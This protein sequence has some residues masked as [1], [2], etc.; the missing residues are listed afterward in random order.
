[1]IRLG[2]SLFLMLTVTKAPYRQATIKIK[3]HRLRVE[4]A[5]TETQRQRGMMYRRELPADHG[6]LFVFPRDDRLVFWM[7]N[8]VIPLSIAFIDKSG[9]IRRILR[10]KPLDI[11][12][13][14]A[15]GV[16]VRYALEVNRGW[17]ARHGIKTGDTV[18]LPDTVPQGQ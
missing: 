4:L 17:F 18:S 8:T 3:G 11:S 13:R 2:L 1:M 10:M 9:G 5:L 14:Y 12:K 15:S 7:K 6:M 16:P